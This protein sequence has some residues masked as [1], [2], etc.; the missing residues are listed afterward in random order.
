[1]NTVEPG[2]IWTPLNPSM[3]APEKAA[4]F[5]TNAPLGRPAQPADLT[6][7]AEPLPAGRYPAPGGHV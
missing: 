3:T 4:D 1:M 6:R 5:G 2:P 7:A